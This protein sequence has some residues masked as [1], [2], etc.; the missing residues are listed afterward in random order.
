MWQCQML[1]GV[2]H[3]MSLRVCMGDGDLKAQ[4]K[5]FVSSLCSLLDTARA[6]GEV[7]NSAAED[8]SSIIVTHAP[9]IMKAVLPLACHPPDVFDKCM[10]AT[11]NHSLECFRLLASVDSRA[12]AGVRL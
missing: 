11:F 5:I 9:E 2:N 3:T 4:A 6:K 8:C 12:V 10:L 7:P 1:V